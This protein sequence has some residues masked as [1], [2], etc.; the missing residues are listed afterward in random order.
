MIEITEKAL[1]KILLLRTEEGFDNTYNLRVGVDGSGCAGLGYTMKYELGINDDDT[2]IDLS[3]IKVIINKKSLI[4]LVGTVLDYSDGLNGK[5]FVWANPSS[6][7]VCG[8]GSSF[9]I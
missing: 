2:V 6:T 9:S 4:Y 8:C 1:S 7:R 3:D 5:G